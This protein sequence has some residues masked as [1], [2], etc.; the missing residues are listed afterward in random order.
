MLA[1]MIGH[2]VCIHL[3]LSFQTASTSDQLTSL[4]INGHYEHEFFLLHI[5]SQEREE[6][7]IYI[8]Y[9]NAFQVFS[10]YITC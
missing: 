7:K 4:R 10:I 6:E 2:I 9:R 1:T 5:A 3:Y 8:L